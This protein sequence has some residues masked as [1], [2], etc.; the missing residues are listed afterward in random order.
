MHIKKVQ[1]FPDY[2]IDVQGGSKNKVVTAKST[3]LKKLAT[4]LASD[5]PP[6]SETRLYV[7]MSKMSA[8]TGHDFDH[9]AKR[10][11]TLDQNLINRIG[12]LVREGIT[13]VEEVKTCLKFYVRDVLF[14]GKE[15]PDASCRAFYP[16]SKDIIN[17]IQRGVKRKHCRN[18]DQENVAQ[19]VTVLQIEDGIS[20]VILE[21]YCQPDEASGG[22][23]SAD[24]HVNVENMLPKTAREASKKSQ[25][26]I[27]DAVRRITSVVAH[28]TDEDKMREAH[29]HM[30]QAYRILKSG[31][32]PT[33]GTARRLRLK[34]LQRSRGHMGSWKTR[35]RVGDCASEMQATA[36]VS[37]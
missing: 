8:H 3:A 16:T 7:T 34:A 28:C 37:L 13:S 36:N 23:S 15:P 21:P 10:Q 11:Q 14:A 22:F 26:Q 17:H 35:K 9:F 24:E 31:C 6:R 33:K 18:V 29:K 32:S 27:T 19:F 5:Q 25:R 20:E 30:Q 2:A 12:E 1:V 4:Q